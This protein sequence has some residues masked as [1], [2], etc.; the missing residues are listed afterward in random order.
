M[1]WA[2][3]SGLWRWR[4]AVFCWSR[5]LRRRST[6]GPTARE[7]PPR[8]PGQIKVCHRDIALYPRAVGSGSGSCLPIEFSGAA[9][10]RSKSVVFLPALREAGDAAAL[11][12]TSSGLGWAARQIAPKPAKNPFLTQKFRYAGHRNCVSKS[13]HTRRIG[14]GG[15]RNSIA[16]R[17]L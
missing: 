15:Q 12:A 1:N 8:A 13:A 3:T 9:I 11:P 5:V 7:P 10:A 14:P 4:I 17:L 16:R 6:G 2:R